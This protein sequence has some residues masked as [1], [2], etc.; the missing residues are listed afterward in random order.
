MTFQFQLLQSS[1]ADQFT[2]RVLKEARNVFKEIRVSMM[3]PDP[4]LDPFKIPAFNE[5]EEL[6]F[7]L[8]LVGD[9]EWFRK[10]C[11]IMEFHDDDGDHLGLTLRRDRKMW[12]SEE[13]MRHLTATR[14]KAFTPLSY[15]RKQMDIYLKKRRGTS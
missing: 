5:L 8:A 12:L 14:I 15:V 6:V 1:R 11:D 7:F 4:E 3:N 10:E 9:D 13:G 2:E